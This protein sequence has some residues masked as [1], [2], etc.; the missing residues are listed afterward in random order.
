[1]DLAALEVVSTEV[2]NKL[3]LIQDRRSL[4]KFP[5]DTKLLHLVSGSWCILFCFS[6][7]VSVSGMNALLNWTSLFFSANM[8]GFYL[9]SVNWEASLPADICTDYCFSTIEAGLF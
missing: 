2:S 7:S 3:P 6:R 4:I 8:V 5:C 9:S 1:M